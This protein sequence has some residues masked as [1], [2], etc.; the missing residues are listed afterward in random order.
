VQMMAQDAG[1]MVWSRTERHS[2]QPKAGRIEFA[3]EPYDE[4][5][6]E[7]ASALVRDQHSQG[8][9]GAVPGFMKI[10]ATT[11]VA[12]EEFVYELCV[13]RNTGSKRIEGF[14]FRPVSVPCGRVVRLGKWIAQI[15]PRSTAREMACSRLRILEPCS[16]FVFAEPSNWHRRLRSLRRASR[17]YDQ[18]EQVERSQVL[19][20][21]ENDVPR[22]DVI[23]DNNFRVRMLAKA[24]APFGWYGRGAFGEHT[25]DYQVL[26][27]AIRWDEF[28]TDL[29]R[30]IFCEL[31]RAVE[32]I[33]GMIGSRS[34]L[35]VRDS[36]RRRKASEL[37]ERLR[38]GRISVSELL[39]SVL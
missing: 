12:E 22:V 10:M 8:F 17:M 20:S 34:R 16:T 2:S 3:I 23:Y 19:N 24:V 31:Q 26:E 6:A 35:V 33:A 30:A 28:C 27:W 5:L 13:G 25:T 29:A 39:D 37:R 7:F 18:L 32:R 38:T 21:L 14:A 15:V 36:E 9:E 4:T 1:L 11:V